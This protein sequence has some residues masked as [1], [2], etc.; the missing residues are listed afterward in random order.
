MAK[1][2]SAGQKKFLA[3][4]AA[5]L[6][7]KD[8]K[9]EELHAAIHELKKKSALESKDA[10]QAIYIA[11]LGKNSGPQAG[12][13]LEALPKEFVIKRFLETSI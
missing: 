8:W 6:K 12:W 1:T 9:G 3:D 2:L 11:L 5:L 7:E 13:F 4:I 10:F